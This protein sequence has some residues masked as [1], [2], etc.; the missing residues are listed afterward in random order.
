MPPVGLGFNTLNPI[1]PT[2]IFAAVLEYAFP[3]DG[4]LVAAGIHSH[5]TDQAADCGSFMAGDRPV[6][7][8]LEGIVV[9][10]PP[11]KKVSSCS[12][13]YSV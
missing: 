4:D 3:E 13:P 1:N 12:P 10:S 6:L 9:A 5:G 2:P 7:A 8:E 11:A